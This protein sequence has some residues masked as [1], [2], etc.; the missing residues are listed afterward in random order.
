MILAKLKIKRESYEVGSPGYNVTVRAYDPGTDRQIG[1][2]SWPMVD[3]PVANGLFTGR[4]RDIRRFV[5]RMSPVGGT[6]IRVRE[7][8]PGFAKRYMRIGN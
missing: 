1:F 4:A 8:Y 3:G 7:P 6:I 2:A 5:R